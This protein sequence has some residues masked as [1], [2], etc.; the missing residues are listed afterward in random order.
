MGTGKSL[1]PLYDMRMQHR[2]IIQASKA[3]PLRAHSCR[4]GRGG[5]GGE[6]HPCGRTARMRGA[7]DGQ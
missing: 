5:A 4:S 3:G 1:A 2:S 7:A 6:L